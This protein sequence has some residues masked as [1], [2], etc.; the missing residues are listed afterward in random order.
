MTSIQYEKKIVNNPSGPSLHF[1]GNNY[2]DFKLLPKS[3]QKL[4][5]MLDTKFSTFNDISLS[6]NEI[7]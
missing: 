1:T 2:Q 3:R 4:Q 5:K 7:V 6:G